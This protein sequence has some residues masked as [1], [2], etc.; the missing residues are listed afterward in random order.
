MK[1]NR[2][3]CCLDALDS[4]KEGKGRGKRKLEVTVAKASGSVAG[5]K[6]TGKYC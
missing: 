5:I 4:V 1:S 6:S 3:N 2:V